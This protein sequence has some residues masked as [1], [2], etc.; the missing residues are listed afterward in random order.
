ML[1]LTDLEPCW[2]M[3]EGRRVGFI[4]RSPAKRDWWQTCFVER[5]NLFTGHLPQSPEEDHCSADSQAAIIRASAPH[6]GPNWQ[7]CRKDCAWSVAGGIENAA[8]ET[9]SVTPSLDGSAGGL[10][11]GFIAA[12]EIR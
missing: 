5:F 9:M 7:G 10:W 3:Y 6:V 12:G 2:L 11:H 8:F 4:F 1:K